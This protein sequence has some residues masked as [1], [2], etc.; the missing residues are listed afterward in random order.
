MTTVTSVMVTLNTITADIRA[1]T[2]PTPVVPM[3]AAIA[4]RE[5]HVDP[6]KNS[7]LAT[8]GLT[9]AADPAAT[10]HRAKSQS[11]SGTAAGI[12]IVSGSGET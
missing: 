6:G 3:Q 10:L 9:I 7:G 2:T 8:V 4:T 5:G 11:R 12:P 1:M